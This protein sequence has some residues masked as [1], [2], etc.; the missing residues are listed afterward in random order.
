MRQSRAGIAVTA[1]AAASALALAGCTMSVQTPPTP[2]V[3]A[4]T[5][6]PEPS[7]AAG[8]LADPCTLLPA[9]VINAEL[10]TDLGDGQTVV[11]TARKIVTCRYQSEDLTQIVGVTVSQVDGQKS[12][13]L[14]TKLAQAYFGGTAKPTDVPGADKAYLVIAETFSAPVVGMLVGNRF[15]LVQVGVEGATPEQGK[16]L[17]AQAASRVP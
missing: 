4:T 7:A 17:A 6:A 9:D 8:D 3:E 11:D 1:A 14:N 12:Y 13:A 2:S 10:G 16:A 15:L 5:A